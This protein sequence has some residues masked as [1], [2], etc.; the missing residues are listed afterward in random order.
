MSNSS[1]LVY[2]IAMRDGGDFWLY[3]TIKQTGKGEIFVFW[4]F[5]LARGGRPHASYHTNGRLHL[6]KKKDEMPLDPHYVQR[7]D[8]S[9]RGCQQVVMS[10][11]S[12]AETKS[13]NTNCRI[14]GYEGVFEIPT[15]DVSPNEYVG[16]FQVD[17]SLVK[18][19]G[20]IS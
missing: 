9:F 8:A 19:G 20:V 13:W 2:A 16:R 5:D 3:K 14:S 10:P 7:P 11:I 4:A 15:S 12:I 6:K 1:D 17:V 18:P